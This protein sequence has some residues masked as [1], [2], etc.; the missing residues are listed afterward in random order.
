MLSLKNIF[1][2]SEVEDSKHLQAIYWTLLIGFFLSY[3]VWISKNH[4][5]KTAVEWSHH[6]CPPYFQNCDS[7]YFLAG[8]PYSYDSYILYTVL[9]SFILV[10]A[11]CALKKS[12]NWAIGLLIPPFLYKFIYV[13]LFTY[14]PIVDFEYFHLPL[15]LIFIFCKNKLYFLKRA[16][17]LNYLFAG[18]MK[19]TESW[20]VGSYFSSIMIGMPLFPNVLIPFITNGVALFEGITPW[21][22]LSSNRKIRLT[23]LG[24]WLVF[25]VYS[26]IMV[27]FLYPL[28]CA[29]LLI[30]FFLPDHT[31]QENRKVSLIPNWKGW[32]VLAMLVA[33]NIVPFLIPTNRLF[34]LQGLKFGVSMFDANHQFVSIEKAFFKDGKTLSQTRKSNEAM[35]RANPYNHWFGLQHFCKKQNLERLE[36]KYLSSVNGGP[37]YKLVDT[38]DV[39]NLKYKAFSKN[40]WLLTPETGAPIV[41]YPSFSVPE[42]LQLTN[43]KIVFDEK[44]VYLSRLQLFIEKHL[45]KFQFFYWFYWISIFIYFIVRRLRKDQTLSVK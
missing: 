14:L 30:A 23:S 19:F 4:F 26:I 6:V 31:S 7:L 40:E 44:I 42:R 20:I 38:H 39:C 45:G 17:V 35:R 33:V 22:L 9:A 41:G 28:Y 13:T 43:Q 36:W 16:W 2:T 37:F 25:H 15:V 29:P 18:T 34:T 24:M 1:Y 21:F 11:F 3:N 8:K 12:W 10:S 5:T 32:L 27:G